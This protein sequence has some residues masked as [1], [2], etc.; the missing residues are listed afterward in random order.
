MF[1]PNKIE[2]FSTDNSDASFGDGARVVQIEGE[3][4]TIDGYETASETVVLEGTQPVWSLKS[5]SSVDKIRVMI[6]GPRDRNLGTIRIKHD[7]ILI[8][9]ILPGLNYS[10]S[11]VETEDRDACDFPDFIKDL[12]ML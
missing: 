4:H 10:V 1:E 7:G 5:Y 2:I 11:T 9:K 3:I 6:T 12:Q 8:E